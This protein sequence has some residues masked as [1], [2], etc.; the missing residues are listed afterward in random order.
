MRRV[1]LLECMTTVDEVVNLLPLTTQKSMIEGNL[2]IRTYENV[3]CR[4][5]PNLFY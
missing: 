1:V 2:W 3:E 4:M 5:S